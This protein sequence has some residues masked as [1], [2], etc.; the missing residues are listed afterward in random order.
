MVCHLLKSFPVI[1]G[2]YR[3][4]EAANELGIEG[5]AWVFWEGRKSVG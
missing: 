2:A 3:T 5:A 1:A 4:G